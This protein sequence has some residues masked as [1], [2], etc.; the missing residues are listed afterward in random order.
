MNEDN[1]KKTIV[2]NYQLLTK[3][4]SGS[5]A[6]VYKGI[7]LRNQNHVALKVISRS[8]IGHPKLEENLQSEINILRNFNHPN[9][10]RLFDHFNSS[11]Y[12]FLVLELCEGGDL[13][14]YIKKH[15]CI[16]EPISIRF[17]KQIASGLLF[18]NQKSLIHRDLKP[19]NILLT[20]CSENAILKLADFGFCK[21]KEADK[22]LSTRCGTPGIDILNLL[23]FSIY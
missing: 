13:S 4:G 22:M 17:L 14:N 23:T 20:E 12:I 21:V 8:K 1:S 5:Y 9:I 7:D 3:I 6:E 19:A 11:K 10:V 18:L 16:S 2:G 15:K